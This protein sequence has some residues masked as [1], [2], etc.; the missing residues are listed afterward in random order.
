MGS[1]FSSV[2]SIN[3]PLPPS[4][5][6]NKVLFDLNDLSS[7]D[8]LEDMLGLN[9]ETTGNTHR[10]GIWAERDYDVLFDRHFTITYN[11]NRI[12]GG[13]YAISYFKRLFVARNACAVRPTVKLEISI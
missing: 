4:Y 13:H 9:G 7:T 2:E 10:V 12:V 3:V 1:P 11:L 5:N 6:Q 8:K